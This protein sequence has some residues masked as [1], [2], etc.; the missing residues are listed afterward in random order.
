M[1]LGFGRK[2]LID[3]I[4]KKNWDHKNPE[5]E[6]YSY[7]EILFLIQE[8]LEEE[9]KHYL[10][11]GINLRGH[12]LF[13]D[14]TKHLLYRNIANYDSM[15][16]LTSQKG[17]GKS[18]AAIMLA[19]EWCKLLGIRFD[20]NRHIAYT[21]AEVMNKID[22][23][24][25]FEPLVADEAI[26]FASS[27]DWNK[28][29]N[30]VLKKKLGKIRTKHLLFILC[31]PL[32]LKKLDKT[33]LES[34]VNYWIDLFDRGKGAIFIRDKNPVKDS[35]RMDDFKNI[36]SYTEF[37]ILSKVEQ[38][39]KKHPNFWQIIKFP[40]PPGWLYDK[41]L[42]VREKNI[43]DNQDI[44]HN[45][46]KEDIHNA[47]LVLALRDIMMHDESIN[48]NRILLHIKNEYDITLTK[49]VIESCIKDAKQLV[50]KIREE[51]IEV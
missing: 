3:E 41:Y 28:K 10:Q 14:L 17:T 34:Y 27:E 12:H 32:K 38:K 21:N 39:L 7:R 1:S 6:K 31:F 20:P 48:I 26:N 33:Y 18:S 42:S 46:A 50:N 40:K 13:R 45:V 24:N 23:L 37:T 25:K 16:L 49:S 19:R 22:T 29:E 51:M 9:G 5:K 15:L 44:M 11:P 30:K 2:R 8:M 4:I 47:L 35:W 36:G 43:Y